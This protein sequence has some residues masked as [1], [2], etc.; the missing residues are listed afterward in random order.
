MST[1]KNKN[2]MNTISRTTGGGKIGFVPLMPLISIH[3][4]RKLF[5]HEKKNI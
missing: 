4:C 3:T 1:T 2:Y 5:E